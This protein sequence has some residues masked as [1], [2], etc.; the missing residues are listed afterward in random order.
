MIGTNNVHDDTP[1]EIAQ[2]IK[3]I[4]AELR[5]RLP[6]TQ[7]LLLGVFPRS[8]K[9]D[10]ARDRIKSV[11]EKIARLDDGSHVRYLDIG[12]AFLNDDGTIS[13]EIMPD[14]LHLSTQGLPDLGRR[15]GTD[16]LVDAR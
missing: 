3:A 16:P 7:V 1:D 9:P 11:N 12:K 6:K 13:R 10:A 4:V 5:S 8:P 2:G 14:Y 15:H